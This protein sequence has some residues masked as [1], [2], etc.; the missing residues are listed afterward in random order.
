MPSIDEIVIVTKH[1]SAV[2][3]LKQTL[4]AYQNN[5]AGF[6]LAVSETSGT[7]RAFS[8]NVSLSCCESN[9]KET[10]RQLNHKLFDIVD[11][12]TAFNVLQELIMTLPSKQS[13]QTD[14]YKLTDIGSLLCR[15]QFAFVLLGCYPHLKYALTNYKALVHTFT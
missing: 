6:K 5:F 9:L 11:D 3:T 4:S 12:S 1:V 10:A 8:A 2:N 13:F 15:L 7:S 14:D